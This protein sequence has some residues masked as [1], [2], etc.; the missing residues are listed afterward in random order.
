MFGVGKRNDMLKGPLFLTYIHVGKHPKNY[1][2]VSYLVEVVMFSRF[3]PSQDWDLSI[4]SCGSYLWCMTVYDLWLNVG[5]WWC[6]IPKQMYDLEIWKQIWQQTDV[7][8]S[9]YRKDVL[10]WETHVRIG[11]GH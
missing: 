8:G 1:L 2:K 4:L 9:D 5:D 7:D 6:S 10:F 11:H 3:E